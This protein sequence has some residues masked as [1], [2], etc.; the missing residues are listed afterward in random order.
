[1]ILVT[2]PTKS[3]IPSCHNWLSVKTLSHLGIGFG[4]PFKNDTEEH[5]S[6]GNFGTYDEIG[7]TITYNINIPNKKMYTIEMDADSTKIWMTFEG[8]NN[9]I[10]RAWY[11]KD[12]LEFATEVYNQIN[13]I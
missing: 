7:R 11:Y 12:Q 1:M 8:I 10:F 6:G 3:P 4:F 9:Q 2:A 5:I 13:K